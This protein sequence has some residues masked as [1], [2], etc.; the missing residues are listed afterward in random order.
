MADVLLAHSFFLRNDPKQV[1]KMR[2]YAPL[3]TLY[4]AAMLRQSG[5]DVALFDAMLA[6]GEEE[7]AVALDRH[8]PRFVAI[9]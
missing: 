6:A 3:A 8:R 5:Y 1:E 4:A 9:Y 2:P 7:L